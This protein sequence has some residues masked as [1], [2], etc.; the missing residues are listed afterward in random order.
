MKNPFVPFDMRF[1]HN[2]TFANEQVGGFWSNCGKFVV[3]FWQI[4]A[5]GTPSPSTPTHQ[6]WRKMF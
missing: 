5:K 3:H 6:P 2:L 4:L 1:F